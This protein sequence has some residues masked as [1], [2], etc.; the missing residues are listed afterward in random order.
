MIKNVMSFNRMAELVRK[1]GY[2]CIC[3]N[4]E[5]GEII[6]SDEMH[7]IFNAIKS[8]RHWEYTCQKYPWSNSGN[9]EETLFLCYKI[10]TSSGHFY[11]VF[12]DIEDG[13]IINRG[14]KD[15]S[16]EFA[17]CPEFF[18]AIVIE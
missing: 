13:K 16:K 10:A 7:N 11:T 8:D 17:D 9:D 3:Y 18:D 12:F 4:M 2:K 14:M 1:D 6:E 5:T 15:I